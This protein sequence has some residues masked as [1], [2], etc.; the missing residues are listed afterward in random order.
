M[1]LQS[2]TGVAMNDTCET[3]LATLIINPKE[4]LH[5]VERLI[6][7]AQ[8]VL[9]IG[10]SIDL[11]FELHVV[12]EELAAQFKPLK[13]VDKDF[14]AS[15]AEIVHY[16]HVPNAWQLIKVR[17]G[18]KY[19]DGS[20][21]KQSIIYAIIRF[22]ST[23]HKTVI[24]RYLMPELDMREIRLN[25]K[26]V[27][28]ADTVTVFI[29]FG[30]HPDSCPEGLRLM[31][32]M[33]YKLELKA[34]VKAEKLREAD[35]LSLVIDD[36]YFKSQGIKTVTLSNPTDRCKFGV[37]GFAQ[38]LKQGIV[39]EI[40]A[41]KVSTHSTIIQ[42]ATDSGS[43]KFFLGQR[44]TV[45][46]LPQNT[47]RLSMDEGKKHM[48]M[49]RCNMGLIANSQTSVIKGIHDPF[50][51]V[52]VQWK[53]GCRKESPWQQT[54]ANLFLLLKS[55]SLP[56]GKPLFYS[57]CPILMGKDTGS[58]MGV[59]Y[60]RLEVDSLLA[61]VMKNP[62]AWI[63]WY[64]LEN[65]CWT[66]A[67]TDR[68]FRGA[69]MELLAMITE[70]TDWN[71]GKLEVTCTFTD[72]ADEFIKGIEDDELFLDLSGMEMEQQRDQSQEQPSQ[73][74]HDDH[75][76]G[77][78]V[79]PKE[80]ELLK[81]MGLRDDDT[82]ASCNTDAVSRVTGATAAT[83]GAASGRSATSVDI[84]RSF[85]EKV[86]EIARLKAELAAASINAANETETQD[87]LP[88]EES[89][90]PQGSLTLTG[91]AAAAPKAKATFAADLPK[92]NRGSGASA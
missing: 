41:N 38:Q 49:L 65:L 56:D 19:A 76:I 25:I 40:P 14:P 21:K 72:A 80:Q 50:Y 58:I 7:R 3:T 52:S 32:K 4:D 27:Q 54:T 89:N 77:S 17:P 85:K 13:T 60:R 6:E 78:A 29:F 1:S 59:S 73:P 20:P 11:G 68:V 9:S 10:L 30:V 61:K 55:L 67:C 81:R 87:N 45:A 28:I 42:S 15:H 88:D 18:Q 26:G 71:K 69:D 74:P 51:N 34:M 64:S 2:T 24:H 47:T 35:S 70:T 37:E 5:P 48:K 31:V 83:N 12:F 66:Q 84:R 39:A 23:Y 53:P 16:A 86:I 75:P 36:I 44:A 92:V 82:F 79:P 46:N 63:Y 62:V 8:E 90:L 22:L 57:L 33:M 91:H 43:I